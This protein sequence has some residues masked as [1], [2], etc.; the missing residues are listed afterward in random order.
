MFAN[1]LRNG[2][3]VYELDSAEVAGM[4]RED[5]QVRD[6][7]MENFSSHAMVKPQLYPIIVEWVP[8]SFSPESEKELWEVE[9]V[10]TI[11]EH[12][13]EKA[14]WIK[15]TACR[16]PNQRA[17]HLILFLTNPRTANHIL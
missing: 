2:G 13:I 1:K 3:L 17:A 15:P 11:E 14:R 9:D 8:I 6:T 7:F 4:L 5:A 16:E 10:N 12:G